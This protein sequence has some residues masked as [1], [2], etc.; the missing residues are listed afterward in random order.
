MRIRC[1]LLFVSILAVL[2]G[3]SWTVSAVAIG[4]LSFRDDGD[5]GRP[6]FD[7]TWTVDDP[8]ARP[9]AF[10][11]AWRDDSGMILESDAGAWVLQRLDRGAENYIADGATPERHG[12]MSLT[13]KRRQRTLSVYINNR[14]LFRALDGD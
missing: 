5:T 3:G 13:I 11:W 12:A 1:K 2:V 8:A 7:L 9:C 4:G 10:A 6:T 14:L